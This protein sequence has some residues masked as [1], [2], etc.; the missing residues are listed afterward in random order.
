ME[1]LDEPLSVVA[2]VDALVVAVRTVVPIILDRNNE[3][4]VYK[5]EAW[6]SESEKKH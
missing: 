3:I 6:P 2:E 4:I 1:T 5:E